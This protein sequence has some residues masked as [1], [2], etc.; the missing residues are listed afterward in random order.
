[1]KLLT[2]E[3]YQYRNFGASLT[4]SD[5]RKAFYQWILYMKQNGITHFKVES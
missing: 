3:Q 5:K 4:K 1:M 2:L